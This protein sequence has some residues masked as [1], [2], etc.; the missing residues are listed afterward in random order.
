MKAFLK[1]L[2]YCWPYRYRIVL[3]WVCGLLSATLWAGSLGA[4]LPIF[5]LFFG[6]QPSS[7]HFSEQPVE[8]R[9][10][11]TER[12]LEVPAD[13]EVHR[14]PE[15]G[16]S[17][18]GT[19]VAVAEDL[20]VVRIRGGLG[21]LAQ[22]A[23]REGKFYAPVAEAL[24]D[25]LPE[26]RFGA[27]L[28]VMLVV[29]AMVMARG[30]L[31]YSSE[32]L[33]GHAV[34]RALLGI[35]L[36]AYEHVLRARMGLFAR[37]RASDVLSRFQNDCRN[38]LDGMK[39]VLGKV[40]V[41]PPRVLLC[42]AGAVAF[43]V[44]I[45]PLLPLIVL[46]AG[47]L[48]G[49]L[50]RRFAKRMR[51][52]SRKSL[53]S[54]ASLVGI[55]EEGLF[56]IR[57]VKGYRL[58]GHER[59]RFFSAGRRLIKQMLRAIR[60]DA[61]TGPV[62]E[63]IFTAAAA[64]AMILGG[65]LVIEKGASPGDLTTFFAFLVG[66]LD[67]VRK[68]SNVSTRLQEAASGAERVWELLGAEPEPRYGQ[69]GQALPRHSQGIAF[70]GVSFE[71]IPGK[72]VLR[73]IHLTVTHGEVVAI[74]G[75]T[76]CGKTT[77]VSLLP[78]FF[79]PADGTI[80]VDGV[81]IRDATLR[82]LRD[83]IAYVPQED[84]LFADSVAGNIALGALGTGRHPPPRQAIEQAARAAHADAFIRNLPQGYDTPIG[85]HGTTLSGGERQRVSLARAV[86]RDPAILILDE[87]TSALDEETQSLVQDTLRT[88]TKGR[89]TFLIAHRLSTL[90][91]ADRIVVMD[92]GR[93]EAVG[94]H[95]ELLASSPVYR[96]LREVG[97]AGA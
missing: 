32:Y 77:L 36:R 10:G 82:S 79:E 29:I 68:L 58:E 25:V 86:L 90:A 65:K 8:G 40:V 1:A 53:E 61:A 17:V 46:V 66:A 83:Q 52:A 59:R 20:V 43:G 74:I 63:A 71:Y 5:N 42:L 73:D 84:V 69:T 92:A 45:H 22:R 76:G 57:V 81:D 24:A 96:R 34:V 50:V 80:R 23:R 47:P 18:S 55:V 26:D 33:V 48:V 31:V 13:W 38:I 41:E 9:P 88:F 6:E 49:Y 51:Q 87:A 39:T 97:L 95:E 3:S 7:V 72:P 64:G 91:I 12:V 11:E 93:I 19:T 14:R 67:P 4:V 78:R 21:G 2:R 75:R 44:G 62:V 56:G 16:F 89:T 60:I 70:Q 30:L 85:E 15:A 28:W 27:L 94:T 54:Q 35:Q 37:V